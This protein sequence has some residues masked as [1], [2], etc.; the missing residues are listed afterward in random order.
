MGCSRRHHSRAWCDGSSRVLASRSPAPVL[1]RCVQ[2][3]VTCAPVTHARA[4]DAVH[5]RTL[6]VSVVQSDAVSIY[7]LLKAYMV[8]QRGY[9]TTTADRCFER[10][11]SWFTASSLACEARTLGNWKKLYAAPKWRAAPPDFWEEDKESV[12]ELLNNAVP[13]YEHQQHART[14][15]HICTLRVLTAAMAAI[16]AGSQQALPDTTDAAS[17]PPRC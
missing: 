9:S 2:L 17:L 12:A 1:D 14:G 6:A 3:G 15:Q 7:K 13:V 16:H 4:P 5:V 8:P 11:C 10:V